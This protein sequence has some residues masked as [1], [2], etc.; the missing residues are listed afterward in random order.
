VLIKFNG[1]TITV[2]NLNVIPCVDVNFLD[3][4]AE[5]ILGE[6]RKLCHLGVQGIHQLHLCHAANCD[7][8]ILNILGD[9]PLYLSLNFLCA[10]IGDE[11]RIFAGDIL[12]YL[13]KH[14][15]KFSGSL[16]G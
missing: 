6:K 1:G 2:L 7:A 15:T 14:R 4:D 5:Y 8:V 10:S 12:L 3:T 9:I 16:T 13:M 11:G